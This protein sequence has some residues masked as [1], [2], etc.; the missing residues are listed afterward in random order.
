M[1]TLEKKNSTIG[2]LEPITLRM[3]KER[4]HRAAIPASKRAREEQLNLNFTEALLIY[5][6]SGSSSIR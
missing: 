1:E 5:S 3:W 4:V 6:D 2:A